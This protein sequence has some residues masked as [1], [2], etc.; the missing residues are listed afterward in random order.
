MT[1]FAPLERLDVYEPVHVASLT[2]AQRRAA[3]RAINLIKKKRCGRLKGRIVADGRSQHG[4]YEKSETA[5][6]TVSSDGLLQSIMINAYKS[7]DV[8]TADIAGAYLKALLMRDFLLMKFTGDNICI[9]CKMNPKYK[10]YMV[11]EGGV[12]TLY[13]RLNKAIY[14]CVKSA[15]LWYELFSAT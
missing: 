10:A 13:V 8:A 4:V 12:P 14:G 1:E 6:P 9:L 7:R 2:R 3:L 15:L 5:S 11:M